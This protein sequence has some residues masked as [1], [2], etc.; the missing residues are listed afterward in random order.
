MKI[1]PTSSIAA[2]DSDTIRLEPIASIDLMERAAACFTNEL[3][4]NYTDADT[5][6]AIFAGKGNNGGDALAVARMLLQKGRKVKVWL[7]S[8]IDK[9]SPD[10]KINL[11]RL[12][13][14]QPVNEFL[15]E[16][17]DILLPNESVVIDGLFGSGL[18]RPLEGFYAKVV[19][20]INSFGKEIVAID[21][22]SGLMGENNVDAASQPI[23]CASKTFTF[24]FPKL[25]MLFADNAKFT[26]EMHIIDI[27]LSR[28]AIER[29][30]TDWYYTER[31]DVEGIFVPRDKH[32]HK[33]CF[34]RVL[35]I[36][37]S[38]GMAGASLLAARGALR[39][40]AGLLTVHVPQCNNIIVQTAVPEAMTSIDVCENCFSECPDLN[41][42]D[43]VAVGPGIGRSKESTDALVK[44]LKECKVPLVIDADALNIIAENPQ[45][46]AMLPQGTVITPHPGEF[47]RLAGRS[48]NCY[49]QFMKAA[50]MARCYGI[51]VVLKGAYTAIFT[52]NGECHFNSTGNP[53]MATGG[54]GDVLTG[55]LVALLGQGYRTVDAIRLGVYIHGLA[56]DMAAKSKG[57]TAMTAGDIIDSLSQAWLSF[58]NYKCV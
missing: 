57:E 33:G 31:S 56:G 39:S 12:E 25:S 28:S 49:A 55:V 40:G 8:P 34:G 50:E 44:L 48:D 30:R 3:L 53:G 7:C 23:I 13:E 19:E 1:F 45:M 24:Q 11:A 42:Y 51:Y 35:L 2:I 16:N 52:P 27:S 4:L 15:N 46:L 58:E 29:T 38:K 37:G 47:A 26:G 32:A 36:A 10:C 20:K 54:S 41:A 14:I 5:T 6:F 22:P 21:I 9:L 43:A 18:N 17:I